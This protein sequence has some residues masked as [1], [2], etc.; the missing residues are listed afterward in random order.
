MSS[1]SDTYAPTAFDNVVV[2]EF[3]MPLSQETALRR[4][5]DSLFYEDAVLPRICRIDP[6]R[7][8]KLFG[9]ADDATVIESARRFVDERF[10]GYS[11]YRVDGRFRSGPMTTL[12]HA[13]EIAA[14]RTY[15]ADETTAVCRFVF[16]CGEGDAD[17]VRLLFD[18][19][20]V[21]AITEQV[22][23]EEEIWVIESGVRN[24]IRIWRRT[25]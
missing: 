8:R 6:H 16:P 18:E 7:L 5:L 2:L 13:A 21:T 10:R 4:T 22:K 3:Y 12:Q 15:L 9:G 25:E 11:I 1:H 19:L 14:S 24:Q 20:F 23:G 17:K